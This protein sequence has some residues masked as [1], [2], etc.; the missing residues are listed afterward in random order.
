MQ[1]LITYF[2]DDVKAAETLGTALPI[3]RKWIKRGYMSPTKAAKAELLTNGKFLAVNY[4]N[5]SHGRRFKRNAKT[6]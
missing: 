5:P 4:I 6:N 3:F 2:G 1:K